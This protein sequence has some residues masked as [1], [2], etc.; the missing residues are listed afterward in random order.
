MCNLF[1]FDVCT[2][3]DDAELFD[4]DINVH[5]ITFPFDVNVEVGAQY[6]VSAD[7]FGT[8]SALFCN[9]GKR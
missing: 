5:R 1:G 4:R 8:K 2:S 3:N 6:K 7:P 9:G